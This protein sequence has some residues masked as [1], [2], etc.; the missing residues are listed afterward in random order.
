[1]IVVKAE[2][3][4]MSRGEIYIDIGTKGMDRVW[5][6]IPNAPKEFAHVLGRTTK[7]VHVSATTN[8][9]IMKTPNTIRIPLDQDALR[10]A[11]L[12][13]YGDEK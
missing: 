12:D 1:M 11:L 7:Q 2:E 8:E 5:F 9:Y 6:V 4:R 3:V 10:R 13:T